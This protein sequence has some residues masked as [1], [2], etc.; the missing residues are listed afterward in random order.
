VVA[1]LSYWPRHLTLSLVLSASGNGQSAL[2][3]RLLL[4]LLGP[5]CWEA[6]I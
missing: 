4:L 3:A 2:A 6:V 1:T 5:L